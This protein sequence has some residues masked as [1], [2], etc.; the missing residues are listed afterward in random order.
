MDGYTP[1]ES[2]VV[3]SQE[4]LQLER[5]KVA[6]GVSM[7]LEVQQ[8]WDRERARLCVLL[9]EVERCR[10]RAGH[11]CSAGEGLPWGDSCRPCCV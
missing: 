6:V 7:E 10:Q 8:Q 3:R 4:R 5:V 11:C 9:L 2:P 1:L